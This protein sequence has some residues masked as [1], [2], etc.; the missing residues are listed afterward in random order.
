M[1]EFEVENKKQPFRAVLSAFM[2]EAADL[3]EIFINDSLYCAYIL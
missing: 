1:S 2:G 3:G